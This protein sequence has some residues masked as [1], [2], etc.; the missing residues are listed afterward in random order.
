MNILYEPVIDCI[1]KH[2]LKILNGNY[3]NSSEVF[4]YVKAGPYNE[5]IAALAESFGMMMVKLEARELALN[6]NILELQRK[7]QEIRQ[8]YQA[9]IETIVAAIDARDTATAGHSRRVASYVTLLCQAINATQG[10]KH[11][12]PQFS[13]HQIQELYYAALLHDVGK[14]GVREDV[15]LKKHR[16]S[17]ER[18]SVIEY[19]FKYYKQSLALRQ[20]TKGL[21]DHET[22]MLR[23]LDSY[24][25]FILQ[26]NRKEYI[27]LEEEE[28]IKRVAALQFIN[29]DGAVSRILDTFEQTN[30]MVR[31]GN[32]TEEEKNSMNQH[33]AYTAEIL[34]Y[35]PWEHSMKQIP[36]IAAGH[37]EKMDGSGYPQ[38]LAAADI[39]IQTRMLATADIFDA[40][41]AI[42]R[43]YKPPIPVEKAIKILKE[44]GKIGRL[45][46]KIVE[47]F[48]EKVIPQ[49]DKLIK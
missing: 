24:Y 5:K 20:L 41:T 26:M 25:H 48:C 23:N 45:D 6:E 18:M 30:L 17:D 2:S 35:I 44:E 10:E 13:N 34:K 32:L 33:A 28:E 3:D 1:I 19:R 40:L 31:R 7:E 38:G 29:E 39:L 14:I 22:Q 12:I 11:Q 15:L 37:H 27:S 47:I 49:I 4:D 46:G 43:P 8:L 9:F 36:V 42:D 16:L 21:T